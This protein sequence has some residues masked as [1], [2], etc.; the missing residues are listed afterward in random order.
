M[1]PYRLM[2][3]TIYHPGRIEFNETSI[4]NQVPKKEDRTK[5]INTLEIH[6]FLLR[7]NC[8]L[9]MNMAVQNKSHRFFGPRFLVTSEIALASWSNIMLRFDELLAAFDDREGDDGANWLVNV[10][11]WREEGNRLVTGTKASDK[12][13]VA[14]N[15]AIVRRLTSGMVEAAS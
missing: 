9:F 15:Q 7:T 14:T 10:D 2:D 1:F 8:L 3:Q 5:I 4:F 12:A 13:A 6:K 11:P